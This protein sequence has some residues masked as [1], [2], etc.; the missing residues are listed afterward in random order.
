MKFVIQVPCLDEAPRIVGVIASLPRTIEGVDAVEVLFI[1]D[2]ST[3]GTAEVAFAAGA[4]HLVRF[5]HNRGPVAFQTG[6][7]EALRAGAEIIVNTDTDN[8]RHA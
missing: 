1:D 6:L 8:L 3:N 2:G 5:P 7:R 4:D